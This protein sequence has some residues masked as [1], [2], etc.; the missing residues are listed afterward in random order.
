M[1]CM[2]NTTIADPNQF[3]LTH[4]PGAITWNR[5]V[6]RAGITMAAAF[7]FK[8]MTTTTMLGSFLAVGGLSSLHSMIPSVE[9]ERREESCPPCE[10]LFRKLEKSKKTGNMT[11]VVRVQERGEPKSGTSLMLDWATGALDQ[12][13]IYLQRLYGEA[14][15]DSI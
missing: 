12:T 9:L 13:C 14:S 7:L 3:H 1:S 8:L 11:Q 2:R 6:L 5:G 15:C 10:L 4:L